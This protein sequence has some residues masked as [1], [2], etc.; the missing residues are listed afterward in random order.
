MSSYAST[1]TYVI[2]VFAKTIGGN[3]TSAPAVDMPYKFSIRFPNETSK[4]FSGVLPG[5][6]IGSAATA[7]PKVQIVKT[8]V[9]GVSTYQVTHIE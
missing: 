2:E 3:S 1:D 6:T 9:A 4:V 7:I 8:T 5:L